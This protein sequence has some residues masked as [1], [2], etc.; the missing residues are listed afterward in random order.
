MLNLY[1]PF[2]QVP[3]V[4]ELIEVAPSVF[5]LRIHMPFSL[6]HINIWLL[7]DEDFWTI[8]DTGL[9]SDINRELWQFVTA[10][11][12]KGKPIKQVVC[13]HMHPDHIGLAGWLCGRVSGRA[14][15]VP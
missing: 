5:W 12:F 4:G 7:E 1:Y 3:H 8:V 11:H 15:D 14:L 10:K 2:E 9:A 13:T 6:D